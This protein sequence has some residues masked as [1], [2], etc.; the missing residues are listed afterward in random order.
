VRERVRMGGRALGS[1][2]EAPT[3]VLDVHVVEKTPT[4]AILSAGT[5]FHQDLLGTKMGGRIVWMVGLG[6]SQSSAKAE[7]N[8]ICRYLL[9]DPEKFGLER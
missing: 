1:E 3:E 5:G 4:M 9:T 8:R 7:V 6:N 2:L